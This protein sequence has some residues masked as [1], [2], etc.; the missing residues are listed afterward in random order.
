MLM[1]KQFTSTVKAKNFYDIRRGFE[2]HLAILETLFFIQSLLE[3]ACLYFLLRSL[4]SH[5]MEQVE[6]NNVCALIK[7]QKNVCC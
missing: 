4:I 7:H 5:I 3:E 6:G 2:A 1:V